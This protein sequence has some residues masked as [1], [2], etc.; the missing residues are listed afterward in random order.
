MAQGGWC[1]AIQLREDNA[2]FLL[3][4]VVMVFYMVAGAL[5]FQYLEQ[6]SELRAVESYRNTYAH[7]VALYPDVNASELSVLLQAHG[8][9]ST[10]NLLDKRPRWDF[11]GAFYFVATIVTTIGF[12]MTTPQT[13]AGKVAMMCYG[14]LGCA[15]GILFFNLFL[16]RIIS[17]LAFVLRA[18][19][20]GRLRAKGLLQD[21]GGGGGGAGERRASEGSRG[22]DG[23]EVDS[24]DSWKPSVYWVMVYLFLGATC[25]ACVASAVYAHVEGWSYF[26]SLYYC[27]VTYTTIGFGDMVSAQRPSAETN[28]LYGVANFLFIVFGSSCVYSLLNVI[29]IVIKQCLNWLIM[30]LNFR[31]VCYSK[32]KPLIS[33]K[34]NAVAPIASTSR[35]LGDGGVGISTIDAESV[36][37]DSDMERLGSGEM[38]SMRDMLATNKVSLAVMQKQLYETAQ[39]AHHHPE[40]Y[41]IVSS[42]GLSGVIGPLAILNEKLGEDA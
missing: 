18:Y 39:R 20:E 30:K 10:K 8:N 12:G 40:H 35:R 25:I 38:I 29:S 32:Q 42:S 17:F 2:R 3:L 7:F 26:D 9:A 1:E 37:I 27:L 22:S 19:H 16:E 34:R 36:T 28:I 21:R 14:L 4:A 11:G 33:T 6:E 31:L 24:L 15:G 23:G 5:L 41:S 13:I